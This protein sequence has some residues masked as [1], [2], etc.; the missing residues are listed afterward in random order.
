MPEQH[1]IEYKKDWHDDYLKWICGF[2]NAAGGVMYIGKN[3]DGDVVHLSDFKYLMD[4]IPQKIRNSLGLVCDV[5][6][7]EADEKKYI[8]IR[9]NA[10][11]VPV[12]LRGRYYYRSGTTNIELTGLELNEFLLKKAGKTWDDVPEES[13][14]LFDIDSQSIAKFIESSKEKGRMPEIS[15]LS[16]FQIL[17]KL[18]LTEGKKLK[19]AAIILFAKDPNKFYPNVQVKIGRF[20]TDSTDLLFHEIIEGNLVQMLD[21]VPQQL[22]YKFLTRPIDFVGLQRIERNQYPPQA[23]REMLLNAM[24]HRSYSGAP[25]QIRVHNNRISIWNQGILPTGL[26]TEDLKVEHNSFP[27]N[28]KIAEACFMA[29]YIDA[30]GRGTLKIISACKES[31]LPEPEIQ[32]MNGGVMATL[33]TR[34][35]EPELEG[36]GLVD[37]LV[38]GLVNGLVDKLA[39]SQQLILKLIQSNPKILIDEMAKRIGISRTAIDKNIIFLKN[40]N[41]IRRVGNSK[42]G[43]WEII[44]PK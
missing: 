12:S 3:D 14:T 41:I 28:P 38:D 9:T 23:I 36:N 33:F 10:Y 21:A 2:A 34:K 8:E 39:E 17:E 42:T 19:R 1:N 11:T 15:G 16:T 30:W 40:K 5:N 26:K 22:N 44:L 29:G 31:G 27:R 43:Y 35:I 6:L 32:E 4:M 13:A 18:R 25:V 20:G 37:G 7:L 24:V